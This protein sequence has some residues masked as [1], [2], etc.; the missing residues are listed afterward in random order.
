MRTF[1]L[2][3][4][5]TAVAS[6]IITATPADA[7]GLAGLH[8]TKIVN[9]KVCMIDHWHNGQSGAWR[10][11]AQARAVAIRSWK[12]LV[13]AEYGSAWQDFHAS[14]H[15]KWSCSKV[16]DGQTACKVMSRPCRH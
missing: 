15:K 3:A 6:F 2:A 11:E 12:G 14:I 10:S 8:K 5:A 1:V 7:G 4:A 13:R 9:G 16:S